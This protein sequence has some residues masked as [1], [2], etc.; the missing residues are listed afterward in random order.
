MKI[1]VSRADGSRDGGTIYAP[2]ISSID[3]LIRRGAKEIDDS[4]KAF[5]VTIKLPY[6]SGL[7]TGMS[8]GVSDLLGRVYTAKIISISHT[9]SASLSETSIQV[10]RSA[11]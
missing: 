4:S 9:V 10:I 5:I 7:S 2:M 8:I 1:S 11:E 3:G 6:L